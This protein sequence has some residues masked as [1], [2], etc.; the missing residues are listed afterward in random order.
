MKPFW[1]IVVPVVFVVLIFGTA[2]T[3]KMRDERNLD[4][5]ARICRIDAERG[6]AESEY[7]LALLYHRGKGVPRDYSEALLWYQKAAAQGH[8]KA[9]YGIGYMYDLGQGLPQSLDNALIWYRKAADQGDPKAQLSLGS[10]YYYGRGLQQD[11]AEAVQWY[12]KAANQ[13][14]ARAQYDLGYMYRNGKGV[15]QDRVEADSWYHKAADQGDENA[16]RA[17]GL[18]GPGLS[19]FMKI[20]LSV[21]LLGCL[22]IL[23]GSRLP[24]LRLRNWQRRTAILAGF[25]GMTYVALTVFGSYHFGIRQPGLGVAGFYFAKSLL[26]GVTI[27]MFLSIVVPESI[28]QR[29]TKIALGITGILFVAFNVFA[30]AHYEQVRLAPAIRLFALVNGQLIGL[31]ISL[32]V[33]LWLTNKGSKTEMKANGDVA[34]PETPGAG[35]AASNQL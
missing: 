19:A 34:I 8:T 15:P 7:K 21:T 11:S 4:D 29:G 20:S 14:L 31:S 13:G 32:A 30:I 9:E 22:L 17:L 2:I 18:T 5:A 26:G 6:D 1:K 23:A 27:V 16:Q 33:F 3:W 25:L 24:S 10:M 12:R 28:K 35:G